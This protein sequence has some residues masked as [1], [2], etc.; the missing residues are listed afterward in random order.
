M[1]SQKD[2]HRKKAAERA[3]LKTTTT[4]VS[5]TTGENPANSIMKFPMEQIVTIMSYTQASIQTRDS[6]VAEYIEPPVISTTTVTTTTTI[7]TTTVGTTTVPPSKFN[8]MFIV[9]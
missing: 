7:K 8:T 3:L 9:F 1:E 2:F 6:T 5:T 4:T